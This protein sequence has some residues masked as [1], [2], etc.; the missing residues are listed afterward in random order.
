[1]TQGY[2]GILE[3]IS[4]AVSAVVQGGSRAIQRLPE[5][6]WSVYARLV[7]VNERELLSGA[8]GTDR[9]VVDPNLAEPRIT[10]DLESTGIN[11][12]PSGIVIVAERVQHG[13]KEGLK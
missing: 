13:K 10:A 12:R 8:E 6:L 9:M 3:A 5:I 7:S 1:V 4:Q 2:T 11:R